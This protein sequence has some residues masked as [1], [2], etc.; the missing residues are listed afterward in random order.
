L[1]N[2]LGTLGGF[3]GPY[4]IGATNGASGHFSRGL[5]LV[6][7]TLI[8]SAITILVLRLATQGEPDQDL[9]TRK[10]L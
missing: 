8:V 1:I 2:S 5:Y 10:A 4:M 3:A 7:G 9:Q 6:G